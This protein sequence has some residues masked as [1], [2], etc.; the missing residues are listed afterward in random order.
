MEKALHEMWRSGFQC[1]IDIVREMDVL[2]SDG[3]LKQMVEQIACLLENQTKLSD[4]RGFYEEVMVT[5]E[6]DN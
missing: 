1:A 4:Q 6:L 2:F 3:H 5:R